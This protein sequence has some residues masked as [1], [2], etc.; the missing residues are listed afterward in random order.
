MRPLRQI[1]AFVAVSV[2]LLYSAGC[3][4]KPSQLPTQAKAPVDTVPSTLPPEISEE[5]PPPPPLPQPQQEE[6]PPEAPK[7][8]P[9]QHHKKKNPTT[10]PPPA[11]TAQ[12]NTTPPAATASANSGNPTMAVAHPPVNPAGD[13]L[14]PSTAI[15]A[16]VNSAA[17][18]QQ[19]QTTAQLLDETEKTLNGLNRTLSHDEEEI[20]NQIRSY[21]G[22]SRNATKSGDF[23][24]AYNLATKAHLLSDALAKK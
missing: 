3:S 9:A 23:E 13:A 22:Q 2:L 11:A 21:I 10:T 12:G 8:K 6:P 20:V 24:R 17:L 14:A 5:T 4:K 16:D 18:S 1:I 15:G 7:P 19:K